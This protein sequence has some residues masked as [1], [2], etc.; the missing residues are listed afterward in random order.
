MLIKRSI[1]NSDFY[2]A[3]D[4]TIHSVQ[5]NSNEG[6][7]YYITLNIKGKYNF[8]KFKKLKLYRQLDDGGF[9]EETFEIVSSKIHINNTFFGI[10]S[11]INMNF[12]RYYFK[13]FFKKTTIIKLSI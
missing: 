10:E 3:K 5:K 6:D 4:F 8:N 13:C 12:R 1:L 2:K 9:F 7:V 11:V